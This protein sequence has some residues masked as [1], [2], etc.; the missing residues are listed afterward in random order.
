MR[1]KVRKASRHQGTNV[2]GVNLLRFL[3][4]TS[5][6]FALTSCKH[7]ITSCPERQKP[8]EGYVCRICNTPGHLVRDCPTRHAVGDTGG[9]KPR[10]GYVCRACASEEHYIEDCPVANAGQRGGERRGKRDQIKEIGREH[11]CLN[12]ICDT[13]GLQPTN[14]GSAYLIPTSRTHSFVTS[15]LH[16]NPCSHRKHL[17]VSIGNECYVTLPKGQIIPTQSN[18]DGNNS[19]ISTVPGGGHVLIVPIAHHPTYNTIPADIAPPILE[20]TDKYVISVL[21]PHLP[22]LESDNYSIDTSLLSVLST[23]PTTQAP[24]SLK[25]DV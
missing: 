6:Q 15:L 19:S 8:P 10:P 1:H 21:F 17:I 12:M 7:F 16:V 14:A 20:E 23:P 13:Y 3:S 9:R 25:S 22:T 2:G 18:A 5:P 11:N 4:P 24:Y